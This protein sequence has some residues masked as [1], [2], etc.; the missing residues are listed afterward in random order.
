[1]SNYLPYEDLYD[2]DQLVYVDQDVQE[3]TAPIQWEDS[4]NFK[5]YFP[6]RKDMKLIF[7]INGQEVTF[8]FK[9]PHQCFVNEKSHTLLAIPET[10]EQTL[11]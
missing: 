10:Y 6:K 9:F 5:G 2:F 7:K 3:T 8:L 1:M 4:I 11:S